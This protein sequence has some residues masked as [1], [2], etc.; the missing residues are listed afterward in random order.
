VPNPSESPLPAF[1]TH[2]ALAARRPW[3]LTLLCLAGGL[4]LG[5]TWWHA[6]DGGAAR[7]FG[8]GYWAYLGTTS[9]AFGTALWGLWH[10]RRWALW[11]FPLSLLLDDAVVA[12]MGELHP[13]VLGIELA[14]V[15]ILLSH[16]RA[17]ATT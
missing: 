11:A 14:L 1:R 2:Q 4:A 9:G 5:W 10:L 12:A 16:F 7:A 3:P 13:T 15:L 8:P 17:F 6:L